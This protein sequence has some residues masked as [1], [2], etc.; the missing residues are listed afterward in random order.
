MQFTPDQLR[1]AVDVA[2]RVRKNELRS[3]FDP[4]RPTS[5][6]TEQ[7][8]AVFNDIGLIQYRYVVAGNQSGKSALAAREIAWILCGTHPSWTRPKDWGSGP[9]TIII[10]GQDRKMMELELWGNKLSKFLDMSEW[11]EVR[12]GQALTY[13]ENRRTGDRVIFISHADSSE[14]NRKHMQGYV[15]HYVWLDEMPASIKVLEELQRRVDSNKGYFLATFTP[16]FKNLA[17]KKL[18][19]AQ[20]EPVGKRYRLSK[21]DNPRFSADKGREIAKLAGMS[22]SMQNAI[23]FGDWMEG[24][25]LVY[26]FDPDHHLGPLPEEYNYGWRHV[27]VVDPATES[28]LGMT[29]WAEEPASQ[30]WWCVRAEYVEKVFVPTRIVQEVERRVAGLNIVA[31]RADSHEAWFIHTAANM[32]DGPSYK[33]VGIEGKNVAGKKDSLIKGFQQALGT[34][35]RIADYCVALVEEIQSC[36]RDPDSGKI[37]GASRFHLLDT[38]HYFIDRIPEP[39]HQLVYASFEDRMYQAHLIELR[40]EQAREEAAR[41][42]SPHGRTHHSIAPTADA[43][44]APLP[45]MAQPGRRRSS[46]RK[47]WKLT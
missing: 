40:K 5:R 9:L 33:Y 22:I 29:V 3:S 28:K 43:V 6:P 35:I 37:R 13:A 30:I 19:E 27:L 24:D 7:Q 38:C 1:A 39:T 36:E 26:E 14:K 12:T 17:I 8:W 10:A 41:R 21:L 42:R 46:W 11:R 20:S 16:K 31:R 15:A 32:P 2:S 34:K 44:E 25:D 47:Q 23:L 18:V 45:P 4:S